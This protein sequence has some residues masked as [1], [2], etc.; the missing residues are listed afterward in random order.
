MNDSSNEEMTLERR[1]RI[2]QEELDV[3]WERR[4]IPKSDYIRISRAYNRHFQLALHKQKRLEE[5]KKKSTH[6]T[7]LTIGES[8]DKRVRDS[9]IEESSFQLRESSG[10]NEPIMKDKKA[11]FTSIESGYEESLEPA[12][13][14][15]DRK[16]VIQKQAI[17]REKP[18]KPAKPKKTPEQIR[19]RNISVILLTGV[20]LLLFG[21]L[22]LAT[23]SWGD[24]NA[25]LKVFF[26]GMVSVIF[27]GM[28]FIASKLKI[29]QTSFAFLTLAGLFIPITILSA[30]YYRIFGEYLSLNG[31]GRGLLGFLGGF[32]CLAIYYKIADY[33]KSKIF[34]F[35]SIFTF[36]ITCYFGLAFVTPTIEWMLLAI[37]ILN[38]I[39][40]WNMEQLKNQKALT[41]FKPFIFQFIQFKLIVEAFVILT[42][43]S[44][45]L[46]YSLT[47]MVFSVLFLIFSVKFQKKYYEMAFSAVFTYGYIHLVYN[48][49]ISEYMIIAFALVPI[50]FTMLSKYLVKAKRTNLSKNFMITSLIESGIVFLYSNAMVYQDNYAQIFIALMLVS[51]QLAYVSLH[52]GNSSFTYPAVVVFDLAFLYLFLALPVSFSTILNLLFIVQVIQYLGVYLY[53]RHPRYSLFKKSILLIS[54]MIMLVILTSKLSE[55][56]WLAVSAELAMI[57]GLFFITYIK[58]E[59]K[60]MKEIAIYG[61]PITFVLALVTFYPYLLE[62]VGW[63]HSNIPLSIY[64]MGVSLISISAAYTFRKRYHKLFPVFLYN[65]Q[66]ISFLSLISIPFDPLNPLEASGVIAV[67]TAINGWSV[68]IQRKHI[69][70]V[71][72]VITSASL[73]A[74]LYDV[75][76]FGSMV[77]RIAFVLLG[78]LIFFL[79]GEW[80]GKYSENGKLYFFYASH[81]ANLLAIPV[82]YLLIIHTESSPLLYVAQLSIYILSALRAH[83]KWEKYVFTYLGFSVLF[84]QVHLFVVNMEQIGFITSISMMITAGLI[85][86]L[87]G[88]SNKYRKGIMEY[89]L[90][91]FIHLGISITILE[92][93]IRDFPL[94]REWVWVGVMTVQFVFAWYLLMKRN[95][96]NYVAVPLSLAF[97]FYNMYVNTL[98]LVMAIII[99]LGCMAVMVMASR[100]HFKGLVNQEGT[101]KVIDHYRIFGLLY[102]CA[103]NLE[104]FMSDTASA[105]LGIFVSLLLPSYFILMERF[106]VYKKE[107]SI[108]SGIAA[109][110]G[111]FPFINI[112]NYAQTLPTVPSLAVLFGCMVGML[113]LSR[114]SSGSLKQ[115]GSGIISFDPFRIYGLFFL[116]DMNAEV[117]NDTKHQL[118]QVIVSLLLT[119]YFIFLRSLT[120]EKLERKI[121]SNIAA[122]V[123]LYPFLIIIGYADSLSVV[124]GLLFLFG[125]MS[126]MLLLSRRYF[127]G[128][129]KREEAGMTI[130]AYRIYGLLFLLAM[131]RGIPVTETSSQLL[132]VFVSLLIT[133]Y[134]ILIKSFTKDVKEKG[135]Y[136]WLTGILSLYPYWTITIYADTLRPFV[137]TAVLFGCTAIM[138]LLSRKYFKGL[139]DKGSS[140]LQLDFYRVYGLLFL[141]AMNMDVLTRGP[142]HFILEIFVAL[143]IPAYFILMRSTTTGKVERKTQLAA[144]ILFSL[145]PYWVIAD[146]LTIPPVLV[147]EVNILPLFIVST[148]L[149]R[150]IFVKGK[151]TQ[152]IE[153]GI[154]ILLFLALIIDAMAGNTIY[155]A[156]I[157]GTVSLA[158]MLFGFMMKYKSYF[159]AGTGTILF[160]VYMNTNSMWGEMPWWLYLIIGG[161]L[162]IGIAS[163]FEWKKQKDN[164]TSKEVL[165]KNKQK[166]KNWLNRWN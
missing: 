69:F 121:Y 151:I 145:Y 164:R 7:E 165:E 79:L 161:G 150:K 143:L 133:V 23:T 64:L 102:L 105:I 66:I 135:I 6:G 46:V 104:V 44:S 73:Y 86:I 159:I 61:F 26:I 57:S 101:E 43:F 83:V 33:F 82:G 113:L 92:T 15:N 147:E 100:R 124:M 120:A 49:F 97:I 130:D 162:L 65:G 25:V 108:Y 72:V 107:K 115:N 16:P 59:S 52:S 30:S 20:I 12:K 90:I 31:G 3:L 127:D 63:V 54:P 22:I 5:E 55:V 76:D 85:T 95:W 68:H 71:P 117:I 78:P 93:A 110:I 112:I 74:S 34:I 24:L 81:L 91:P 2:F 1:K 99:L 128:L 118:L 139:L 160:N 88:L 32:L 154:V 75:F 156:L 114:L 80:L 35:I 141:L 132:Q 19:E 96:R 17:K 77:L 39:L 21:G 157:I 131:N 51:A 36:G 87:W 119:A 89:Y 58:D 56:D 134:F 40:V 29:E 11:E 142:A 122:L 48:S 163:F 109:I 60:H 37:G 166:I 53:N 146:Q 129:I 144:A 125:C 116:I 42:L 137:G 155:D 4:L 10:L 27:A 106:T 28:A 45:N 103:L 50:I 149:L 153:S 38:L 152:Y 67:A 138:V 158:A 140:G 94:N 41:L 126:A 111:L 148:T 47:L 98:P 8:A 14:I 62:S 9:L 13:E 70:W 84:L 18:I 123:S 136:V